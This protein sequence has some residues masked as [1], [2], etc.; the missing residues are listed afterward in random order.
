[1]RGKSLVLVLVSSLLVAACSSKSGPAASATRNLG[2]DSPSLTKLPKLP[3]PEARLQGI[4]LVKMYVTHNSF[5]SKP[6]TNQKF[7]FEPKCNEGSCDVTLG[8]AMQFTQGL[9]DRQQ[10]GAEKRFLLR[11]AK[12]G[13]DYAGTKVGYFAS[14]G[15]KPDKDRWTFDI[16]VDK[17]RYIDSMW[18]VVHWSGTWTRD[19][20]FGGL[21]TPGR[22]K[23]VIRG[24]RTS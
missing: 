9:E 11:L 1:M 6:A 19:S 17:A 15:N 2:G 3:L 20:N 16:K 18:T 10:A 5:D 14:C 24:T 23:T 13:R 8:G 21:C 12:L 4:Y 7:R 22:L